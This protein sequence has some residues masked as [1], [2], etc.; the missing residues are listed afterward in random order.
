VY[1]IRKDKPR[2]ITEVNAEIPQPIEQVVEKALEKDAD[3]RYQQ[4]DE[5]LDDLKSISAGIVPEEI[6]A[7]LRKAKLLKRKRTILYAGAVGLVVVMAVLALTFF[8]SRAEA[9]DSI[10]V[11]PLENLTGDTEQEYFVEGMTDELIGKLAQISGLR[12]VISRR[13]VM[14]YKE[15]DKPLPDIAQELNVDAIVEGTVY[16][17]GEKVRVRLQLIAALPEERSL[18][19]QTYER[20]MTDVLVMYGEMASAIADQIQVKLTS[21]ETTRLADASQVNPEAYDAY[22][23]G[24]FHWQRFNLED[25][26]AAQKYFES[27]LEID[28]EYALAYAGIALVRHVYA[29]AGVVPANEAAPKA[30]EAAEKAV[31]LNDTLAEAHYVLAVIRYGVEWDWEKAEA[32]FL[33]AIELNP[34]YPDARAYY[35]NFLLMMHRPEEAMIQMERTME[36]DPFNSLFQAMYGASFLFMRH[37]DEAIE[38]FQ[39]VLKIVPNHGAATDL[40]AVAFHQKGMFENAFELLKSYYEANDL[41]EGIKALTRGYEKAG[42][43]GAMK[44]TAEM[45]EELAQV[46]YIIPWNIAEVY[47][48]AGNKEKTLDWLEKGFEVRDPNMVVIGMMPLFVDL[49][50]DEPRFQDL[51]RKMKLPVDEKK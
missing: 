2:P 36:L 5:L 48:Y 21:D 26:E 50:G 44:S 14:Q 25:L 37:Y 30:L 18:W 31:E 1:A 38:Q 17:L 8:T 22:I 4:V 39:K 51:L 34:N 3:K 46:T 20:P 29:L 28:P 12:R 47:A 11:L 24:M 35:S 9:I 13:S 27:A 10:A 16:Q 43:Q 40:L 19:T 7:R 6:K 45:W 32:S 15:T 42:Y 41:E 49:L 33:K 23:K